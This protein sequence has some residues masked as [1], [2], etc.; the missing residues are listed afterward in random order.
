MP[1]GTRAASAWLALVAVLAGCADEPSTAPVARPA[2]ARVAAAPVR[3]EAP[4]A[5][6]TLVV[7]RTT[8]SA[9]G[10]KGRG[11]TERRESWSVAEAALSRRAGVVTLRGTAPNTLTPETAAS[12]VPTVVLQLPARTASAVC[13]NAAAWQRES[14]V[15]DLTVIARGRGDEPWASLEVWSAGRLVSRTSTEWARHRGSWR[16]VSQED[17]AV[18]DGSRRT[19]A[20]DRSALARAAGDEVLPR[21]SCANPKPGYV[22]PSPVV[23]AVREGVAAPWSVGLGPVGLAGL[24]L[25]GAFRFA[26][27]ET[28]TAT[29]EEAEAACAM[30]LIALVGATTSFVGLAASAIAACTPPAVITGLP[31]ITAAAAATGAYA[32]MLIALDAYLDCKLLASAPQPCS[33]TTTGIAADGAGTADGAP[34]SRR[35]PT[36]PPAAPLALDCTEPEAPATGGGGGGQTGEPAPGHWATV[37]TYIDYYDE[38]GDY[39]YTEFLGCKVVWIA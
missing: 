6:G 11:R 2:S 38:W 4:A 14:K 24:E 22:P 12:F 35:D 1:P 33:C 23:A 15:G 26:A 34:A 36:L 17:V 37:C 25:A 5:P 10:A 21:V 19:L 7:R 9:Q 18:G 3:H 16:L 29:E 27:E 13:T 31:C 28:C 39:M 20:V 30:K 32:T 8:S